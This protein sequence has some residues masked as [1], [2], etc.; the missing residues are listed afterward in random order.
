MDAACDHVHTA[1]ADTAAL[2]DD[3]AR[4]SAEYAAGMDTQEYPA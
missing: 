2:I 3:A 4:A 1:R